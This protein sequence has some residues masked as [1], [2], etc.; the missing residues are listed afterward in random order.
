[1][2]EASLNWSPHSKKQADV[3]FSDKRITIAGTG[4]QWGKTAVGVMRLKVDMHKHADPNDNFIVTSPTYKILYQSTLPPF[5][6]W[7]N[8]I[9]RYHKKDEM[10]EIYGG[11]KV[12]F[13]TNQNPDSV[14]GITRVRHIL[15]DEAGLYGRYFWD[16]IQARSSF[17]QCPISIVTSPYSLNWLYTD[18]IRPYLNNDEKIRNLIHLCQ[19]RSDENP[20]FPRD[21]YELRRQTMDARRFN[22]IYGGSFDKAEGLVY[23]CFDQRKHVIE[24]KKLPVGTRYF[25]GIDWGFTDPTVI[26]VRGITEDGVHYQVDESYKTQQR[27][28]DT[29]DE[30]YRLSCLYGIE[31]FYADP[32]R[33]DAIAE[34]NKNGLRCVPAQNDILPGIERHYDIIK[35]DDYYVFKDC[36][37]TIDEYETY[38]YPDPKDLKP[39]QDQGHKLIQPVDQMNHA[40]D[41]NRYV[42]MATWLHGRKLNEIHNTNIET[43]IPARPAA[44]SYDLETKKLMRKLSKKPEVL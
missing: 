12:W 36:K 38:H 16:N 31:K 23:D 18:F 9:G 26:T 33:P 43:R 14:V 24:R 3:M 5:L 40:M 27:L 19:A 30:A 25:A 7:N 34:F 29:I 4:I 17:M 20:Y 35:G 42:T 39:N 28:S 22:M 11:G 15:C 1:M 6:H 44:E 32:S 41:S 10:F 37:Y 8:S 21:E 13:R 2:G